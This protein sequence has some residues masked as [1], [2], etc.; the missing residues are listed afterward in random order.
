[1]TSSNLPCHIGIIMDGNGR[2]ASRQDKDRSFGHQRGA[3]GVEAIVRKAAELGVKALTLFGF[4]ESNWKRPEKEIALLMYLAE[5]YLR[6]DATYFHQEKVRFK[7][8]G[9]RQK[10]PKDLINII[11]EIELSTKNYDHFTLNLA[12]SYSG[13]ADIVLAVNHILKTTPTTTFITE[14]MISQYISTASETDPDLIIRT[15]G[16]QRLSDFLL[17]QSAYSEL[18][19][20]PVAWPD[21]TP[22]DLCK[23]IEEYKTRHRRF[24]AIV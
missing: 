24:G 20:T 17:W 16:E 8:I 13:R 6:K 10:L 7:M 5:S 22:E 11:Q 9:D 12:L 21:F 2:W 18:Y 15:S 1:M 19:F 4:A 14:E 3:E 23:A